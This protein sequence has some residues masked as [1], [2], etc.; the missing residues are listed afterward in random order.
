MKF[1]KENAA[2]LELMQ[3]AK[4]DK[5]DVR[6]Y[7]PDLLKEIQ[8]ELDYKHKQDDK[9]KLALFLIAI[10]SYLKDPNDHCSAAIKGDSSAGKD[11][12]IKT[13]L[14]LLPKKDSL[15]L[16]RGT[17]AAIEDEAHKVRI[18]AFSEINKHRENGANSDLTETFKQFAEGG[19]SI[20]KKDA[21]TGFKTTKETTSEQKTLFY[22]TTETES[23]D[24]LETRYVVIP[25]HSNQEKNKI[26]VNDALF[27]ASNEDYYLRK[28]K[29]NDWISSSIEHFDYN[30]SVIIPFASLFTEKIYDPED[31][32]KKYLF[33][34]S[35]E[36]IKRDAKRLLSLTKAITWL[37]QKQ[38]VIKLKE[39]QKFIYSEP[40]DFITAIKIF[41]EFFNLTYTGLDHR[42]QKVLDC[43]KKNHSN[44]AE[45]ILKE[46]GI[47]YTDWTIRSKIQHELGIESINTIKERIK[48]LKDLGKIETHYEQ[49]KNYLIRGVNEG[50]NRVS[51]PVSLTGVDTHLTGW[52]TGVKIDIYAKKEIN[53]LKIKDFTVCCEKIDSVKFDSV[54]LPPS[55]QLE[56]EEEKIQER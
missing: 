42:V 39:G 27:K 7:K 11:N 46:Y 49:G 52:L 24:E 32:Q 4:E 53:P 19:V 48:T 56:V 45:D 34:F 25:I 38:R 28:S 6:F 5:T 41:A 8:K 35:K 40:S 44:H 1:N 36:R 9:E 15:F 17:A 43:I 29:N 55:T 21:A 51:L 3:K 37:H 2:K 31:K 54:N 10:S 50:V 23:D 22:G 33:D 47:D 13:V 14:G 30:L 26:V 12:I 20:I 18:I 16:T